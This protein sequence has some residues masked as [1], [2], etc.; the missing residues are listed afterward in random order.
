MQRAETLTSEQFDEHASSSPKWKYQEYRSASPSTSKLHRAVKSTGSPTKKSPRSSVLPTTVSTACGGVAWHGSREW[1][2]PT[3][4]ANRRT[5]ADT[6][7]PMTRPQSSHISAAAWKLNL[8]GTPRV[9]RC[10]N[11]GGNVGHSFPQSLPRYT[12]S[13]GQFL[14][15]DRLAIT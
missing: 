15:A 5:A 14:V 7:M 12:K 2:S 4:S 9:L 10:S 11:Q 6:A 3:V 1:H 13:L 8:S